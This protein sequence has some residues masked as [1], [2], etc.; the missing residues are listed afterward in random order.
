M[1]SKR[2]RAKARNAA[3]RLP[4]HL[5]DV[6]FTKAKRA[7]RRLGKFGPASEVRRI[8]P[9]DVGL[10]H[11]YSTLKRLLVSA[12]IVEALPT[13]PDMARDCG[14]QQ[15]EDEQRLPRD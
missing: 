2:Q 4:T 10:D 11:V 3:R 5:Q 12:G 7:P 1:A 8:D 9:K 14:H 6:A 13:P 15:G